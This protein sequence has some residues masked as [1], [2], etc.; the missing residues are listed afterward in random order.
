MASTPWVDGVGHELDL[1]GAVGA[2]CR[3]RRTRP[4]R[5]RAR[6]RP[7]WRPRWPGR[8][9]RCRCTSAAGCWRSRR[10]RPRR[11]AGRW[12]VGPGRRRAARTRRVG[13]RL[14]VAP[15]D[16]RRRRRRRRRTRRRASAR[17]ATTPTDNLVSFMRSSWC[18]S[19]ETGARGLV[20]AD[21][22]RDGR[23]SGGGSARRAG[24]AGGRSLRSP[25]AEALDEVLGEHR[26]DQDRPDDA[27]L[28]VAADVG[29]AEAVAQVEHDEDGEQ[30]AAHPPRAAEDAHAAEQHDGDDLELEA[31]R[32]VAADGAEPGGEEDPGQRRR[33][34]TTTMN[35]TSRVR[36][37]STP[38]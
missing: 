11:V 1:A 36:A 23:H 29:Q 12:R 25:A 24:R 33:R 5:R 32:H 18:W 30:H 2:R 9:R 20:G 10:R 37:T 22:D 13:R 7:P 21:G 4:R 17:A 19:V 34:A 6:R 26:A 31:R 27:G 8:T 3:A 15:V 16:R 38:E 14:S 35:S 28:G